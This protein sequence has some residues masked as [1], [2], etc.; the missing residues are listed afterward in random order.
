MYIPPS[1]G[2]YVRIN[3]VFHF[4]QSDCWWASKA[5][6][7]NGQNMFKVVSSWNI[8]FNLITSKIFFFI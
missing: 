7:F 1:Y 4:I 8:L 6:I 5:E 2:K 3:F